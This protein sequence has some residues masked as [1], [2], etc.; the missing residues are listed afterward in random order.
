MDSLD[1][2][3]KF[4][5]LWGYSL[6]IIGSKDLPNYLRYSIGEEILKELK[7]V[8]YLIDHANK[9]GKQYERVKSAREA[10]RLFQQ[11]KFD[12]ELLLYH[13]AIAK[14]RGHLYTLTAELGRMLGGWLNYLTSNGER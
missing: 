10:D 14:K 3:T 8:G 7:L 2:L 12:F 4:K 5:E 9:Q 13:K 1:A 6:I 11:V